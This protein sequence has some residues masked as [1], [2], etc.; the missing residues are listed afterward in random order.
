MKREESASPSN[1][2]KADKRQKRQ[3][4]ETLAGI[5][6]PDADA[7]ADGSEDEE[8]QDSGEGGVFSDSSNEESFWSARN[9]L[10]AILNRQGQGSEEDDGSENSSDDSSDDS[11]DSSYNEFAVRVTLINGF[12]GQNFHAAEVKGTHRTSCEDCL[13]IPS[14][15]YYAVDHSNGVYNAPKLCGECVRCR[16]DLLYKATMDMEYF[17]ILKRMER[18][19]REKFMFCSPFIRQGLYNSGPNEPFRM[20]HAGELKTFDQ[21]MAIS[22][23]RPNFSSSESES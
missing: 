21:H 5:E 20:N 8:E 17:K 7:D 10:G 16:S 13:K 3:E 12:C 18:K 4:E 22:T 15:G 23:W 11:E 14:Y 9:R 6:E 1:V 19:L 2:E